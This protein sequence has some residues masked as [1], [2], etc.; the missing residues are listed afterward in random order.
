[1]VANFAKLPGSGGGRAEA[2]R[3]QET[4]AQPYDA[5]RMTVA[6][7]ITRQRVAM[8]TTSFAAWEKSLRAQTIRGETAIN[9]NLPVK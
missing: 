9:C 7:Y 3:H 4:P 6:S 5:L 2:A 8:S 1:M